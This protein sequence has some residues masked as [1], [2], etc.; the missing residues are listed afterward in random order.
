MKW[1]PVDYDAWYE[2]PLGGLSDRL[3]KDL[4]FSFAGPVK[5]RAI[6]DAGC[7][8]GNYSL[9][10]AR[11]GAAVTG[12]D[13]SFEMLSRACEKAGKEGLN[14]GLCHADAA[15]LPFHDGR[16]DVVL[17]VCALCFIRERRRALLEMHRVL[18]SG[19][20]VVVAVLNSRSPW[21]LIRKTKGLF[22]ESAYKDAEFISPSSLRSSLKEAGFKQ[23]RTET[24]LFYPPVNNGLF[25]KSF[26][27]WEGAGRR[28]VP[29]S[30]AFVA[31]TAV[32]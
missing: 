2:T 21:A 23:I 4:V 29:W 17:S 30:G 1:R 18:K 22:S 26:G 15:S 20:R 27:L 25:L 5:G 11:N 14:I 3:E 8:T 6:L 16:F 32:K 24:C 28:L 9:E 10:A 31:A 7:G 19:G 13:D 12:V